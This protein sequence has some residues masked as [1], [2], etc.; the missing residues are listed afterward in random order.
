MIVGGYCLDLYCE[1]LGV[2][3]GEVEDKFGHRYD[4]V[5]Q[6]YGQTYQ[7]TAKRAK[8]RGWR[9]TRDGKAY[10]PKCVRNKNDQS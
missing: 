7:E 8:A 6:F 9:L 1:N 2:A 10:C 4:D 5:H 3:H